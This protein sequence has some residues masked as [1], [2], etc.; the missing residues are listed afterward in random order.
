MVDLGS[1]GDDTQDDSLRFGAVSGAEHAD[2]VRFEGGGGP[3]DAGAV[4]DRPEPTDD[5]P[6]KVGLE[7]GNHCS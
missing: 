1:I 5:G 2:S 7:F 4:G 3:L 6:I